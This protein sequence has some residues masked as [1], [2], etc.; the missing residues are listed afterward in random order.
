M[1]VSVWVG[2]VGG[3]VGVGVSFKRS[4]EC[5]IGWGMAV[6]K[7]TAKEL[8]TETRL[9]AAVGLRY[10]ENRVDRKLIREKQLCPPSSNIR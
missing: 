8:R 1:R 2:M 7:G 5:M 4:F 10:N 9:A 3:C 6:G